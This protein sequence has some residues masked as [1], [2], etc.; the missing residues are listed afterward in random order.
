MLFLLKFRFFIT[1]SLDELLRVPPPTVRE[2]RVFLLPGSGEGFFSG[3]DLGIINA[4]CI[5]GNVDEK[6]K[7][8]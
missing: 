7:L 1:L 3:V 5:S 2:S 4:S 6:S 8:C